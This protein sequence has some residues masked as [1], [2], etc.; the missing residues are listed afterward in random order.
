MFIR[1]T[2]T[3]NRIS[4]EPYVTYRLVHSTR[5]GNA[6]KQTTL[7]NLGAHF[8]LPQV[9]WPALA[10]HIDELV[11]GQRSMLDT[12]LPE[13]VQ[14]FAQR[15]AAQIIART[16]TVPGPGSVSAARAAPVAPQTKGSKMSASKKSAPKS[17]VVIKAPKL[18]S[19]WVSVCSTSAK[20]E[21]DIIKAIENLSATMDYLF[22]LPASFLKANTGFGGL[23]ASVQC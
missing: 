18:M 15:F 20:S 22:G 14:V 21:S 6:I 11:H 23:P 2:Q 7:L 12:T 5:V 4:G 19:A 13:E 10:Q 16:P 8:D 9:H 1:R 17:A 3:R